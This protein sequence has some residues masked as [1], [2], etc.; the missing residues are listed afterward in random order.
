MLRSE[1]SA[2]TALD[3]I[4]S[5]PGALFCGYVGVGR[6]KSPVPFHLRLKET[7]DVQEEKTGDASRSSLGDG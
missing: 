3:R 4:C 1:S 6:G 5:A 2:T 7:A